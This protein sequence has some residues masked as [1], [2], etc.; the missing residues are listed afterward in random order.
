MLYVRQA[1]KIGNS[2]MSC[3]IL[4]TNCTI[5]CKYAP[6]QYTAIFLALRIEKFI[7]EKNDI[8]NIFAQNIDC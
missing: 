1:S 3:Y 8:F 5:H 6:M 4:D 7:G 2:T